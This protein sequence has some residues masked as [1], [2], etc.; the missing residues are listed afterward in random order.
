MN[1][2][3]A[4]VFR[5]QVLSLLLS[6]TSAD[7]NDAVSRPLVHFGMTISYEVQNVHGQRTIASSDL[8]NI[9][10]FVR[11]VLEEVLGNY[12]LSDSLSVM[13]LRKLCYCLQG[14]KRAC[15]VLEIIL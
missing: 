2:L 12:T 10:V 7:L 15:H 3:D 6:K 14:E 11:E 1:D 4:V 5:T 8:V 9:E 13:W